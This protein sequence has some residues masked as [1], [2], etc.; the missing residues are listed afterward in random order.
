MC[1][2]KLA[3]SDVREAL[4]I[5]DVKLWQIADALQVCEM[6]VTRKFRR[7]MSDEEKGEMRVLIAQIANQ[8]KEV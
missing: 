1:K 8:N 2:A 4:K 7:E 3:N 6:T 5:A